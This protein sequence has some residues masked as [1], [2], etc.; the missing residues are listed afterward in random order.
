MEINIKV[1]GIKILLKVKESI[2]ELMVEY[3]KESGN[4]AKNV[5]L[6]Y[7]DGQMGTLMKGTDSMIY[8]MAKEIIFGMMGK[9]LVVNGKKVLNT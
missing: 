3:M 5:V 7:F 4:R 8:F 1:S 2:L 9:Y 6:A